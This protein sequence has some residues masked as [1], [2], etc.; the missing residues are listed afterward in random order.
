MHLRLIKE[1]RGMGKVLYFDCFSGISG[2]MT[3]GALMDL[4]INPSDVSKELAKLNLEGFS[5]EAEKKQKY[6]ILGTEANVIITKHKISVIVKGKY[7]HSHHHYHGRNF[8][9]I[10]EIKIK[11]H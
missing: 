6:G 7:N 2:D 3:L 5:L 8:R 10:R 4:G 9:V 1:G 11:E